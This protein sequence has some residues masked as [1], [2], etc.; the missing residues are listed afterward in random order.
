MTDTQ[1]A[2]VGAGL[3]G[4][5]AARLL[6][7]AGI[8]FVLFEAR[9][10]L[11]GRIQ[12]VDASGRPSEDGFDLGPSWFWPRMQPLIGAL[13]EELG[14]ADF[15]QTSD[16]DVMFERMS[17]EVPQRYRGTEADQLSM[18]LVGGTAAL[19]Q[20]LVCDLPVERILL[21]TRVT[22]LALTSEGVALTVKRAD[23]LAVMHTACKAIVALPPRLLEATV[24]FSPDQDPA[25]KNLWRE[26][27]TWMATTAK[28]VALYDQPF[29]RDAGLSGT[30]QSLVG[31]LA[32]I[33]DASTASGQAALFGFLR[34]GADQRAVRGQETLTRGCLA[35]LARVF[36]PMALEPHATLLKDWTADP[37][38]ATDLDRGAGAH[39][40]PRD[41]RWVAA[42]WRDRLALAGSETSPSEPGYLAGAVIA[43]ERAVA[44]TLRG[45]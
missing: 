37:W 8:D 36:G 44:D 19:V 28:F 21:G 12:T 27:P 25:V 22:E 9:D 45:L 16:G 24:A 40:V 29:W 5:H 17:R 10:R 34:V 23:E 3:A 38:T 4:L 13:V 43:A 41:V 14:L 20:A 32:E 2:V 31:P 39:V 33:H 18:R 35:Q 26:T 6:H 42:P 11:G 30:A 7:K 1:V 15:R